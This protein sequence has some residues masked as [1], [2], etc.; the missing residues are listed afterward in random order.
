MHCEM[1]WP[2]G[3]DDALAGYL[4]ISIPRSPS[5]S[6]VGNRIL[7]KREELSDHRPP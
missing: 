5:L 1:E 7:K 4:S 2:L 6:N 3:V